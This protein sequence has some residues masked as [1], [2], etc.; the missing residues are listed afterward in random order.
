MI[1]EC[2]PD[3]FK[4]DAFLVAG[5]HGDYYRRA[6]L[7]SI[8]ELAASFGGTAIAEGVES[9]A[10]LRTVLSEGVRTVQGYLL[11]RPAAAHMLG[12][13]ELLARAASRLP[14]ALDGEPWTPNGD[15]L[16]LAT[17]SMLHVTPLAAAG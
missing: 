17:Q 7:R 13:G 1:L 11:A 4:I 8:V 6:V 9:A 3:Y 10:D 15:W 2:R 14:M 12:G 16:R 5:A